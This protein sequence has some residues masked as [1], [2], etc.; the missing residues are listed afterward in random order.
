MPSTVMAYL[1][2]SRT[3]NYVGGVVTNGYRHRVIKPNTVGNYHLFFIFFR[4]PF[5]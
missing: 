4:L 5:L 2:L 3:N 1:S